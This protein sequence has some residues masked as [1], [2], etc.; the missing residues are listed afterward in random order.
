MLLVKDRENWL[1]WRTILDRTPQDQKKK[2]EK[3]RKT[4]KKP[5]WTCQKR[6]KL[7]VYAELPNDSNELLTFSLLLTFLLFP[8]SLVGFSFAWQNDIFFS[9]ESPIFRRQHQK[10]FVRAAESVISVEQTDKTV[11]VSSTG[12]SRLIQNVDNP[13]SW[14]IRT[15]CR[16]LIC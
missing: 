3:K 14:F 9:Q 6:S 4:E 8:T 15:T 12:G 1:K 13:N 7:L 10:I 11:V 5:F 16:S 2:K